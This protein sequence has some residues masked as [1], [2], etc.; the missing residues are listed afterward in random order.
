MFYGAGVKAPCCQPELAQYEKHPR[1]TSVEL[2]V[3]SS[4]VREHVHRKL[5]CRL[6]QCSGIGRKTRCDRARPACSRCIASG[7]ACLGYDHIPAADPSSFYV[8]SFD[9]RRPTSPLHGQPKTRLAARAQENLSSEGSCGSE[10]TN[11][12]VDQHDQ[13][14]QMVVSVSFFYSMTESCFIFHVL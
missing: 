13:G 14:S 1:S 5:T 3:L 2:S 11:S 7:I 9:S 4:K 12:R 10:S 8:F 6:T